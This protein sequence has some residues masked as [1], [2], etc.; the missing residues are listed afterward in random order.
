M[1]ETEGRERLTAIARRLTRHHLVEGSEGN[2]SVRL[3]ENEA[4][5]KPRGKE[6]ASIEASDF[7]IIDF[8]GRRLSGEEAP[9]SEHRLHTEIYKK[10]KDVNAVIHTHPDFAT[11]LFSTLKEPLK[12]RGVTEFRLG[13]SMVPYLQRIRPGTRALARKASQK[14]TRSDAVILGDHGIVVV[15]KDLEEAFWRTLGIEKASRWKFIETMTETHLATRELRKE[16][17]DLQNRLS[18][19][20]I[21]IEKLRKQLRENTHR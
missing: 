19:I 20:S 14:L 12:L 17:D 11:A 15:G 21:K 1:D 5:I 2:L 9:S 7:V 3:A 18:R 16:L 4:L 13:S 8:S 10:R 6:L